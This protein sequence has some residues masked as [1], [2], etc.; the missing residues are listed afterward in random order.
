[1]YIQGRVTNVNTNRPDK[2]GAADCKVLGVV[3]WI[4]RER[5]G[6]WTGCRISLNFCA[7]GSSDGEV[8]W[9]LGLLLPPLLWLFAVVMV[10]GVILTVVAF[11][12]SV[13]VGSSCQPD[14]VVCVV[15][16]ESFSALGPVVR[17]LWF[18]SRLT[19]VL[20]VRGRY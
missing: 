1:M 6:I 11:V 2:I 12:L 8:S 4:V 10:F 13:A 18:N 20:L 15:L 16:F 17:V 19:S 9:C 3:E 14:G 7:V 5:V